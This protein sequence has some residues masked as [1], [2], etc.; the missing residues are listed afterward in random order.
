MKIW[1]EK[2][3]TGTTQV[4]KRYYFLMKGGMQKQHLLL[5]MPTRCHRFSEYCLGLHFILMRRIRS[6]RVYPIFQINNKSMKEGYKLCEIYFSITG[7]S[8]NYFL[9]QDLEIQV[10]QGRSSLRLQSGSLYNKPIKIKIII[11]QVYITFKLTSD[12]YWS[13]GNLGCG[14]CHCKSK[15]RVTTKGY[16]LNFLQPIKHYPLDQR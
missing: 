6:L 5:I 11:W 12:V 3:K 13:E 15:K 14:C 2:L 1:M 7:L 4:R 8:K 9:L 10:K 16:Q